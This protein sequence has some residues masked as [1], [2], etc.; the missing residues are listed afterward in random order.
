MPL[1]DYL[2]GLALFGLGVVGPGWTA[3]RLAQRRLFWMAPEARVVAGG[4]LFVGLLALS[5]GLPLVLGILSRGA[6]VVTAL[7]IGAAGWLVRSGEGEPEATRGEPS[8]SAAWAVAGVFAGL[9]LIYAVAL[10]GSGA[11]TP[12]RDVDSTAFI[13]PT[14]EGWVR[15]GS[16]WDIQDFVPNWG[17]GG[18][19]NT[20][21]LVQLAAMVP[22][23]AEFAVRVVNLVFFPL[24]A[25]A[26]Y[27]L[28][29]E[30]GASR[31]VAL[32]AAALGIMIP[33][34]VQSALA[35]V[36]TDSLA[37]AGI[38]GGAL[39][40][41]RHVRTGRAA[42]LCLAV[43]AFGL[44][45]GSKWY[46]PP[47]VAAV[48]AVWAVARLLARRP[49][50]LRDGVLVGVGVAVVGGLWL[51]RNLVELGSPLFPDKAVFFDA[52]PPSIATAIKFSVFDYVGEL[53]VVREVILPKLAASFSL[54]GGVLLALLAVAVIAALRTRDR[55]A[56][57][58]AIAGIGVLFV[59]TLMP[60]SAQG[61]KGHPD[62]VQAGARYAASGFLL[63]AVAAAWLISRV[64]PPWQAAAAALGLAGLVHALIQSNKL[65]RPDFTVTT[66]D[67]VIAA[68][69]VAAGAA[70]ARA[71]RGRRALWLPVA[72]LV[73]ALAAMGGHRAQRD[74]RLKRFVVEPA[75]KFIAR[76]APSGHTI[77]LTGHQGGP[78]AFTVASF[79]PR[80]GNDVHFVGP[81]FKHLLGR[82]KDEATFR[83][84]L[85]GA[86]IDYLV[87]GA[88]FDGPAPELGWA[89][90][91]GWKELLT[92]PRYTVF[93]PP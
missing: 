85:E 35:H 30:L 73:L 70:A 41:V 13:L 48:L 47:E 51:V 53:G 69:V 8:G 11:T 93:G 44:A 21:G 29:A 40:L 2:A 31:A 61:L 37:A 43:L 39:F 7:L 79:G 38:L 24:G 42:E 27:A 15:S 17:F 87:V 52:P 58:V 72:G 88:D 50:A 91:A 75:Y 83:R 28:A 55:R 33:A 57:A 25:L 9:A 14:L 92:G 77:G 36:Q 49:G 3:W 63:A 32:G 5:T 71:L 67:V 86:D 23:Q 68:V 59:Y 62:G 6:V 46:G 26:A 1:S 12:V 65:G 22:W 4:L 89:R 16:L 10:V 64:R 74:Q 80:I 82:D 19:P 81:R 20:G 56:L 60:Y 45:F 66:R 90:A 78:Q 84:R 76:T 34:A 54:A 18:Y